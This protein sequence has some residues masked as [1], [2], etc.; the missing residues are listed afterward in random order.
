MIFE[1][2]DYLHKKQSGGQGQFGRV[3]GTL[4]VCVLFR[5]QLIFD[6][7]LMLSRF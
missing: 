1:R 4:E 2:F 5:L 7:N 3:I 6:C